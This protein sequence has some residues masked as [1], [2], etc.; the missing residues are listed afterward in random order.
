M[1]KI[2]SEQLSESQR[3]AQGLVFYLSL[4]RS[5]EDDIEDH[6][7]SAREA[8]VAL[9]LSGV[10]EQALIRALAVEKMSYDLAAIDEFAEKHS[11]VVNH[12]RPEL[13]KAMSE[14]MV[15]W[16]LKGEIEEEKTIKKYIARYKIPIDIGSA[17]HRAVLLSIQKGDGRYA[18][19]LVKKYQ[20]EVA[21]V[22]VKDAEMVQAF[23]QGIQVALK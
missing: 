1:E 13:V 22:D 7:R 23:A 5:H 11:I 20:K 14:A 17:L 21:P 3:L 19:L 12:L 16:Y 2:P 15:E 8:G 4:A 6:L 9:D 10:I 18:A